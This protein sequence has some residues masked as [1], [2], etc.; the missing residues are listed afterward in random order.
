MMRKMLCAV[1]LVGLLL[2]VSGV[3]TQ[4]SNGAERLEISGKV[5]DSED[6]IMEIYED[7]TSNWAC[8][9]IVAYRVVDPNN[10]TTDDGTIDMG[11]DSKDFDGFKF[12]V[13]ANWP[14]YNTGDEIIVVGE[15]CNE[16]RGYVFITSCVLSLERPT[17][18]GTEW[19]PM[20]TPIVCEKGDTWINL[21]ILNFTTPQKEL[22]DNLAPNA[23]NT[24]GFA[25]Y[26]NGTFR[27]NATYFNDTNYF[28]NDTISSDVIY[29]YSVAP[30]A[31]G[32]YTAYGK[33]L[34]ASSEELSVVLNSPTTGDEIW[35]GGSSHDMSYTIAGGSPPYNV[36]LSYS[37]D[38]TDNTID[39]T[40]THN[41][42]GTYT[43]SWTP[44]EDELFDANMV[45]VKVEVTDYAFVSKDDTSDNTFIVDST[46]PTIE[47]TIP[48]PDGSVSIKKP[49]TIVFSEPMNQTA[50]Q[51]WGTFMISPNP[52][53]WVWTWI[54]DYTMTGTHNDFVF[55]ETYTATISTAAKDLAG[56]YL[57]EDHSWNFTVSMGVCLNSPVLGDVWT[58]GSAHTIE[59]EI[60][61]GV[62]PYTV[63]INYTT[64][65]ENYNLINTTTKNAEGS[66]SCSWILPAIDSKTV[67]MKII[68]VDG[69]E[70]ESMDTSGNFEIDSTAPT[71]VDY[72]GSAGV[73]LTT[74]SVMIVFSEEMNQAS[75]ESAFILE[76]SDGNPVNG[77]F[78]W[79]KNVM[80]FTPD[81]GLASGADYTVTINT[82]TKDK[83][84]PG[85]S[86]TQTYSWSFTAVQGRGDLI[87]SLSISPSP[88]KGK[89]STVTVTVS[90]TGP[91]AENLSGFLTVK[92]YESRNGET[93]TLLDTKYIQNIGAGNSS[94]A[95]RPFTFDDYG[96]YYF[97]V[98][99][100]S[101]NPTD[102][103][104]GGETT[105][106][107]SASCNILKP[108]EEIGPGPYT[109]IALMVVIVVILGAM[110]LLSLKKKGELTLKGKRKEEKEEEVEKETEE[111]EEK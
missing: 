59:Y 81:A 111:E 25:V 15:G 65:G 100:T 5:Y 41:E 34:L 78:S 52:G 82:T 38:G 19:E 95:S 6:G 110:I 29:H 63:T 87:V 60:T 21:T 104:P 48:S 20:P 54:N 44:N 33:S 47:S 43:Y 88:E 1:L 75:A 50:T 77:T 69:N 18:Y 27:G 4:N 102:T 14:D 51:A 89:S 16:G 91:E 12:N 36:V 10:L 76:N 79:D 7:G 32:N 57:A 101:N 30:I 93:W 2:V 42:E 94:S 80:N 62:A 28:Y 71:I 31:K 46:A 11:S 17:F 56:N 13:S 22:Y 86:L 61:G 9:N 96:S 107:A 35:T 72:S 58:G 73:M 103:F 37:T 49:V 90:N 64:D 84:V 70:T 8:N 39:E 23:N 108:G 55:D 40:I 85:N 66:C 99:V 92:F 74:E 45:T 109:L 68:I 24:I 105:G 67:N 53:G 98:E 3:L 97:R 106:R 83:S 26:R